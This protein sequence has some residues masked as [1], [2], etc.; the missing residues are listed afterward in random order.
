MTNFDFLKNEDRVELRVCI[1]KTRTDFLNYIRKNYSNVYY[2]EL[3]FSLV[4]PSGS[5]ISSTSNVSIALKFIS[6]SLAG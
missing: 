2:D 6:V 4:T 1:K 3:T 5:S